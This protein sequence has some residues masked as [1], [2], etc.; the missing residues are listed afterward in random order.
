MSNRF[1][2]LSERNPFGKA[3]A[4]RIMPANIFNLGECLFKACPLQNGL[5][6]PF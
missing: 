3:A 5:Q 4:F 2:S 1:R 6:R